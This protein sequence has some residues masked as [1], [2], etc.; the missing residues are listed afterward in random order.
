MIVPADFD[1]DGRTD[2]IIYSPTTGQGY[3]EM[4]R[5]DYFDAYPLNWAPGWTLI[6][7]DFNGDG[8]SDLFLYNKTTGA[9]WRYMS[10]GPELVPF[11]TGVWAPGWSIT[12]GDFNGDGYGDLFLYN[13]S[14]G[15]DPNAGRWFRVLFNPAMP[16]G[17][18]FT[19]IAGDIRW[20]N[21]WQVRAADFNGDGI[22]D[23]FLYGPDGHWFKVF[24]T[25]TGARYDGGLWSNDW[26]VVVGDFTND[27]IT[28]IWLYNQATGRTILAIGTAGAGFFYAEGPHWA[29]GWDVTGTDFNG[30]GVTD[31]LLYNPANGTYWQ[32][33][34]SGTV[35]MSALTGNWGA[36]LKI[37]GTGG[38]F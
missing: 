24:F 23:L 22:T 27:H 34:M 3:R 1:S 32:M 9:W 38:I 25:S 35:V 11:E 7:I 5:G 4:N 36:G 18:D 13:N 33:T 17:A 28:D 29:A 14:G 6:P 12:A 15:G 30:D 8:Y 26:K 20:A 19:Y 21:T 2:F 31:L 10:T 37:I 16:A